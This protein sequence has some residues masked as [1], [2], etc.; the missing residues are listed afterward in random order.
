MV[1]RGVT[2]VCL[3]PVSRVQ[4]PGFLLMS[5]QSPSQTQP[6]PIPSLI[7]LRKEDSESLGKQ[8]VS[9]RLSCIETSA[10]V[11]ASAPTHSWHHHQVA[12]LPTSQQ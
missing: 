12:P 9:G 4:A 5:T 6:E 7:W 1:P 8:I 2:Q 10:C 11:R 3:E